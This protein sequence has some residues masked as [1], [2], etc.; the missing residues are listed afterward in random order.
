MFNSRWKKT[1]KMCDEKTPGDKKNRC[2]ITQTLVSKSNFIYVQM[3]MSAQQSRPYYY[4]WSIPFIIEVGKGYQ[5]K[6]PE[7]KFI[8][9]TN[10]SRENSLGQ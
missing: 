3:R 6:Q 7:E 8:F 9:D 4:T 1:E 2:H 5:E 10:L